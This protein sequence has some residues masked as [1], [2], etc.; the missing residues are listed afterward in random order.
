[1]LLTE[2]QKI[3]HGIEMLQSIADISIRGITKSIELVGYFYTAPIN[4][5][6]GSIKTSCSFRG[7]INCQDFGIRCNQVLDSRAF[8]DN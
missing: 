4:D 7:T 1:M 3:R 5:P 2:V 6:W 8:I